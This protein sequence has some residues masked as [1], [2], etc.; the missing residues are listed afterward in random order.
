[1]K[2]GGGQDGFMFINGNMIQYDPCF[3]KSSQKEI[4]DRL[5]SHGGDLRVPMKPLFNEKNLEVLQGNY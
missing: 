4:V 5:N 3:D 1:M 2:E